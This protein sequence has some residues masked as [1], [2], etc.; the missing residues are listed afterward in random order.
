MAIW[1]FQL[2]CKHIRASFV[3]ILIVP[4][5][6]H[7]TAAAISVIVDAGDRPRFVNRVDAVA[8]ATPIIA[9][10]VDAEHNSGLERCEEMSNT[11]LGLPASGLLSGNERVMR[12]AEHHWVRYKETYVAQTAI[13]NDPASP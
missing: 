12:N 6:I 2:Y 8:P 3:T 9:L 1:S 4:G 10:S 7:S 11:V 13:L 5:A